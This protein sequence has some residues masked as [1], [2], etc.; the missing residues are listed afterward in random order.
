MGIQ[1]KERS[2]KTMLKSRNDLFMTCP[3]SKENTII[4]PGR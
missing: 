1:E 2:D 3:F 4:I